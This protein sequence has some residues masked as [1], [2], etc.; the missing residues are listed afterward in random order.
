MLDEQKEAMATA[1]EAEKTAGPQH[2]QGLR[3]IRP[4]GAAHTGFGRQASCLSGK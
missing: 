4:R 3:P 1:V 2:F